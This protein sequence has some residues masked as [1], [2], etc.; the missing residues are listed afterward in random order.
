MKQSDILNIRVL[1]LAVKISQISQDHLV[2]VDNSG[3][4]QPLLDLMNQDDILVRLSAV[5]LITSLAYTDQGLRYLQSKDM[6]KTLEMMLVNC[7]TDPFSDALIPGLVKFFG[8]IA[9]V[10]PKQMIQQHPHFVATLLD[11]VE[12]D[13]LTLRVI[14]FETIGY[15]G[16]SLEGK[17][18]LNSIGNKFI[19]S[20]E[21]LEHFIVDSPTEVRI[22]GMNAFANLIKLDKENQ[23]NQYLSLTE[24]WYQTGLGSKPMNLLHSLL[25]QPFL[26]LRLAV[27]Q[28]FLTMVRQGWG[29]REVLRQPG[30]PELLLNRENEREKQGMDAKYQVF[31]FLAESGEIEQIVG[32]DIGKS[33]IEYVKQGP[34]FILPRSEIAF[35][36]GES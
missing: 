8:N 9:H 32:Q 20:L 12:S 3:L 25:K 11:A 10:R 34:Y 26:E 21:K 2:R 4:L 31:M 28:I 24:S 6:I 33:V 13:D 7:K 35:D 19:N 36:E 5:D 22:R 30:L 15:I 17:Q 23:T 29:R 18:A 14:G 16:V 1:E 27:Y